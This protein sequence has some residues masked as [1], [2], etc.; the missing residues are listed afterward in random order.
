VQKKEKFRVL[1]NPL[2][3]I[4]CGPTSPTNREKHTHVHG[5]NY[6][7]TLTTITLED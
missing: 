3:Q 5:V 4:P 2:Q 6:F 1:F 7:F